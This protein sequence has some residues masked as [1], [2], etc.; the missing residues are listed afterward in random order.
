MWRCKVSDSS[1]RPTKDTEDVGMSRSTSSDHLRVLNKSW[2]MFL[3][4]NVQEVD[5]ADA[6]VGFVGTYTLDPI[7]PY[8]GALL[9]E[10]GFTC[11]RMVTA[12]YNQV[13]RVCIDPATEFGDVKLDAIVVLWRIEDLADVSDDASMLEASEAMLGALER[14]RDTF[15]GTIMLG[16]PPRPRA[17]TEPLAGFARSTALTDLWFELL[18]KTSALA[19]RLPRVY[20]VDIEALIAKVGEANA[21]DHRKQ[22]LYRQPYGDLLS[23]ACA[24]AFVRIFKARRFEPK[25]CLVVDCDN[26]LWGG[27]IGEDGLGGVRLGDDFPGSAFRHFQR[28][29]VALSKSGIFIAINSKN[30][31][32]DV[33]EMFDRHSAMVLQRAHISSA[34]INWRPKSEN[35]KDIAKELNIGL[36]SLIFIDDSAFEIEEVRRH[37]PEVTAFHISEEIADLPLLMGLV[38]KLFDRLEITS[39][40]KARVQMVHQES[41][42]RELAQKMTEAEF[43]AS[44]GL[45]AYLYPPSESDLARVTQLIN[46]TNQFNVTTKRYVV[47]EIRE[48]LSD[49]NFD[50]FCVTVRDRFGDY[51]LVG[52]AIVHHQDATSQFDTLLMSCRVLGR[53]IESAIISHGAEL[54]SKRGSAELRGTYISTRKNAMVADLFQRHGFQLISDT[55]SDGGTIWVRDATPIANPDFLSIHHG[56]P[57]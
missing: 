13:M 10:A 7:I 37:A 26:T 24:D 32:D 56:R 5:S 28:Q 3:K 1:E 47:E 57:G 39:D 42:R 35:L 40:D 53:G 41:G 25:K 29:I 54:M 50:I 46:K 18:T 12:N 45:Q 19:R 15:S 51:G 38:S 55:T 20:T 2:R 36:D 21:L 23:A 48:M 9:L 33:W 14:L 8:F 27:I 52:V 34:R 17:W 43:L 44:L 11:P 16:L 4:S 6:S 31:P 30:N 22:L 49:S